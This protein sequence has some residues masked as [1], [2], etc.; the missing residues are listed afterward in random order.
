MRKKNALCFVTAGIFL[1]SGVVHAGGDITV[2]H[3]TY[4]NNTLTVPR[5]DTLVQVGAAQNAVF[6]YND[7]KL[8]WDLLSV[9][10]NRT[11]SL[12]QVTL[13]VTDSFPKQVFL[14]IKWLQNCEIIGGVMQRL[15]NNRF[16]VTVNTSSP[17]VVLDC[18]VPVTAIYNE[19]VIPLSVYGLSA[20]NYEYSVN[21]GKF[22]GSFSLAQENKLAV[23]Q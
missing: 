6:Q 14:K 21:G 15:V 3:P 20:G 4:Q 11:F 2:S 18:A 13:V 22:V 9:E 16:E 12:D 7:K 8:A 23:S 1:Y 17:N 10:F 19:K 5:I